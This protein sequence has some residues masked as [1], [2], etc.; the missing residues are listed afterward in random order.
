MVHTYARSTPADGSV[1]TDRMPA[2]AARTIG[3]G[4]LGIAVAYL[5]LSVGRPLLMIAFQQ[6]DDGSL[7]RPNVATTTASQVVGVFVAVV[8]FAIAAAVL[9]I[10]SGL[11]RAAATSDAGSTEATT[12]RS[13]VL[14]TA[15]ISAMGFALVGGIGRVML[16]IFTGALADSG[17][18]EAAQVAALHMGNV[19]GGAAGLVAG[20][21]LAVVL[22]G[23]A[24]IGRRA[25]VVG[26][27]TAV[28]AWVM[29]ALLAVG[30]VGFAFLPVQFL[31]P[32][33]FFAIG[34]V[35]LRRG[36]RTTAATSS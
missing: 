10:R 6:A 33:T 15:L 8:F 20:T 16:S 36:R 2:S 31:A 5:V 22:A 11:S 13:I 26:T 12:W 17:A 28:F 1:R 3:R 35:A 34:I 7:L 25:N 18:T 9:V 23:I 4:A 32:I 29:A 21:G 27:P 30:F 19:F 14:A 24:T